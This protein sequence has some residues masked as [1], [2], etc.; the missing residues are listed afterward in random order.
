MSNEFNGLYIS[1]LQQRQEYWKRKYR[2]H[3]SNKK[4][5]QTL[6]SYRLERYSSGISLIAQMSFESD[7]SGNHARKECIIFLRWN[8]VSI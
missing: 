3:L 8:S 7:V 6:I 5:S 2:A 1:I 4:G